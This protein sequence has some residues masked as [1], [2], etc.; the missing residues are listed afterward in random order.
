MQVI[1]LHPISRNRAINIS[2]KIIEELAITL[3]DY[4]YK[5]YVEA[6][7]HHLIKL[8]KLGVPHGDS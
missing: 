5:T 3:K 2:G 7:S 4:N 8:I 6:H 1:L